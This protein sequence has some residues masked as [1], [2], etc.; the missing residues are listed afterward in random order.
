MAEGV[1]LDE[2]PVIHAE[3]AEVAFDFEEGG[4]L[5]EHFWWEVGD[6]HD[7]LARAGAS[8][9]GLED[10]GFDI[11]VADEVFGS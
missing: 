10:F 3:G 5:V 4:S 8:V 1:G 9:N 11:G 6:L 7:L 2:T